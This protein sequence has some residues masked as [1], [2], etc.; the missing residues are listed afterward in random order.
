M[1]EEADLAL[2]DQHLLKTNLLSQRM[3]NILGQLD[4][5]L[6][7]LDK[8]I[9]PLGLQPL[10]RK[11]AN[12]ESILLQLEGKPPVNPNTTNK[13][14][15]TSSSSSSSIPTRPARSIPVT[16]PITT[17]NLNN[18][19][20]SY[21][22]NNNNGSFT[23][24]ASPIAG[25]N[26]GNPI[27]SALKAGGGSG[28]TT[29]SSRL[30]NEKPSTLSPIQSA[31]PSRTASPADETAI[32]MRGPDI[33]ALNEYFNA[34]D[35]VILD[36][37]RMYKGLMEGR[38]GAREAGVKDLSNLVEIGFSGMTQLFLKISR[39][40]MGKTVDAS[41]LLSNGPPTPPIYFSPLPTLQPLIIKIMLTLYPSQNTSTPK[42]ISIIQPIWNQTLSS[43]GE[44]RGDWICRCLSG[45]ITRVE[46]ADEGGIG[47]EGRGRDKVKG[48]VG[49]WE[50]L[51][52][53]V[54]A[55][56]L[57]ITTLFPT[58]PP[59]NL[60]ID[61]LTSPVEIL[62]RTL[63]PT[64]NSIK[65]SLNSQIFIALD[66][67]QSLSEIQKIWDQTLTKCLELTYTQQSTVKV[68]EL[69][70][71]LNQIISNLRSLSLRS[72]PE[73]L[74]DIKSTRS[75]GENTSNI[76]DITYST[77]SYLENLPEFEN[78]IEHLLEKSHS[79]R[80]WLMGSK[81]IPSSVTNAKDEG[82]TVKLFVADVLGTLI[83]HLDARSKTMRKPVGQAFL[84]NN[85]SHI[86]NTVSSFRS[87]II[88]P[89]A[90]DMLNAAFR[91]AKSQYLAEFYSL[92]S[93]LTTQHSTPR[94]GVGAVAS[95]VHVPGTSSSNERNNMKE[96]ATLFFERLNELE[97][98]TKQF[99]LNRQDPEMRDR[100]SKEIENI[101][102]SGYDQFWGRAAGK[103]IEK[104][105]RGSPDDITRRVQAMFR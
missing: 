12:I 21:N 9:A 29:Q 102:R 55:E 63:Q 97:S 49:L 11:D 39:D 105:L 100:S 86:R 104:Y 44:M 38:G 62:L 85:L 58:H 15:L 27:I 99:P 6:S 53:I 76:S 103:G 64:I 61:S 80:S 48:L 77:L 33:M 36:L 3:T 91:D 89:G 25:Y 17:S 69:K 40:G 82:G 20:N 35:G 57:L 56:T 52:N 81:D 19:I 79:E 31:V 65:K 43:F 59:S 1:D 98:L 45:S 72:F 66:L 95:K 16:S 8:T 46:E 93:L 32:L 23:K 41:T 92:V 13:P 96:S 84:L 71:I 18:S 28:S 51:I 87:D 67:Y 54:E 42:T 68:K 75:S 5:R 4:T 24:L 30:S 70:S 34:L 10:T 2:L 37:E 83:I 26:L 78:I 50:S 14:S 22:N 94:F 74:V 90:E 7:R 101:I 60:L 73:L 47:A 88:G